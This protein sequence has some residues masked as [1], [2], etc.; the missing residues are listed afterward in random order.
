MQQPDESGSTPPPAGG[1][2]EFPIVA[3]GASAGGIEALKEFFGAMP[4]DS[5]IA[6]VIIQHLEP[7]SESFMAEILSKSTAMSVRQA[8]DGMAVE[9]NSVY[10]YPPGRPMSIRGGR[11]VLEKPTERTHVEAAINLFLSSLADDR[12][13]TA[14][15]IILSGSS[16]QDSPSGVRAIRAAGGMCMVQDPAS[17]QFPA[18]PQAVIDT[19]LAD[20]VLPPARMPGPLLDFVQHPQLHNITRKESAAEAVDLETILKLLRTRTNSDYSLYR[21]NTV[22]RRIQRRMGLRQV[23][24]LAEYAGLLQTDSE[25]LTQLAKDMLVGVSSFFRDAEV[26]KTLQS[27]AIMPLLQAKPDDAPLRA[28]VA[29]CATGEEVYSIAMLLLEARS[30]VNKRCSIQVFATDVDEEALEAA[31]KG[32]YPASIARDVSAERLEKFF[33]LKGEV[34]QVDKHLREA[35]LFSRHN[36]LADPPFPKLDLISCRNV[37]IYIESAAQKKVLSVFAFALNVGGY[38]LLGKA[39]GVAGKDDLFEPVSKQNRLYRLSRSARMIAD[40]PMNK[41]DRP[42]VRVE[43][44]SFATAASVLPQ[45]NLEALLRHFDASV[46]LIEPDGL[47]LYFH[48]RTEKYLTHPKGA[49][50]LNILDMT[51]GS[52]SAR[53]RQAIAQALHQVEPVRLVQVPLPQDRSLMANLTIVR[54]GD[55]ISG[56]KLLAVIFEDAQPPPQLSAAPV[57]VAAEDEP[58]VVQLESEVKT[59]QTEL[60][61]NLE[62]YDAAVEELKSANE[63]VMSM[64]EELQS[65]N[66]ELEASKEEA[67]SLNEELNAVNS[68]LNDKLVE[69]TETNNDLANL[70]QSTD[71]AT[72]FLDAKLRIRR[73]TP[74]TTQL[75]NV[76]ESDLGR[77]VGH[78]TSNFEGTD[79]ATD[80]GNVLNSLSPIEKELRTLDGRWYT[81]HLLP[82]RTPDR[83]V[84]GVVITLSEVTRLKQA[85]QQLRYEKSYAERVIETVRH[86][87]LVMDSQLRVLSANDAFYET[88]RVAPN[89]TIGRQ[90][91]ELGNR[92][93]DIPLLRMLLEE[94]I[95]KEPTIRDF[96]VEHTFQ[97]IGRKVMLVSGRRMQPT[98][99]MPDRILLTIEDVTTREAEQTQ[100]QVFAQR[101]ARSNTDLEQFAYV[102]SHDLQEPLR[103]VTGFLDI[104]RRHLGDGLDEKS[105]ESINF[106]MDGTQRMQAMIKD[107]MDF[108]RLGKEFATKTEVNLSDCLDRALLNLRAS[109]EQSGAKITH[110]LLPTVNGD[111]S[112]LVRLFQNLIGN[113]IKFRKDDEPPEVHVAIT[114]S[115][116]GWVISVRDNGIGIDMKSS[117]RVFQVFQRLHTREQYEGTGIGLAICRRIVQQHG[118][119]IWLESEVGKGTTFYFTLPGKRLFESR[120]K[121]EAGNEN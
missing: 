6:F 75:L 20:Y 64:N 88:F 86:P 40:F 2:S 25:E 117:D 45:A 91:Y 28:W 102:I 114:Q 19:G 5:G 100:L 10:T 24:A 97:Q 41:A 118:G 8:E 22:L 63:E 1:G 61:T 49:A 71:I 39:E 27:Q 121:E 56:G 111:P 47:I 101:L 52:L 98:A 66:E 108:S 36:L 104:L 74:Q 59:L 80:A 77:P 17:A 23:G 68:Q 65:A 3:I 81:V 33:T 120:R 18:M 70:L 16:G 110:S 13:S 69:L 54:T 21:K 14:V 38:L 48:G 60:R 9:P 34:Y 96:R 62:G 57:S 76:I 26:F 15:C 50:S 30:A 29:G 82:Y 89:D 37:L 113:A 55:R 72:I 112:Q 94:A 7:R 78:I 42:P 32:I 44:A 83:R 95:C 107:L 92:Q 99:E 43:R 67:Q 103:V 116:E 84:D 31:R 35:V 105:Q 87:L 11:L 51:G 46:V 119:H 73:F 79:L 53:L 4:A 58:L 106:V 115:E 93:W 12:G 90:V 109:I 85:E